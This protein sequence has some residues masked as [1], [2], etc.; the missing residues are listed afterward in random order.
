MG[1]L[2]SFPETPQSGVLKNRACNARSK[3]GKGVVLAELLALSFGLP[4]KRTGST[5]FG[6]PDAWQV[7]VQNSRLP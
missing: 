5:Y 2:A 3:G 1:Q 7:G 6:T 4:K